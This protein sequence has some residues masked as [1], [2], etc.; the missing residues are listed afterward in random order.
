M[1]YYLD[2]FSWTIK[3]LNVKYNSF[4]PIWVG[5]SLPGLYV[6]VWMPP[7]HLAKHSHTSFLLHVFLVL[8]SR[9]WWAADVGHLDLIW[10]FMSSFI[11]VLYL[12]LTISPQTCNLFPGMTA[13][14]VRSVIMLELKHIRSVRFRPPIFTHISSGLISTVI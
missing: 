3:L 1:K 9:C 5:T 10:R 14:I 4:W 6:C 13:F 8:L 7:Q 11:D 2:I 12:F